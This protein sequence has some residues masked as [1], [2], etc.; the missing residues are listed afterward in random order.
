MGVRVSFSPFSGLLF[1][2]LKLQE[3]KNQ[4]CSKLWGPIFC[5]PGPHPA[6]PLVVKKSV[7]S[8]VVKGGGFGLHIKKKLKKEN[9]TNKV[10][11]PIY[12]DGL[13]FCSCNLN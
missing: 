13:H 10:G 1:L 11:T 8:Q 5:L 4:G 3:K 6:A 7:N 12:F 2:S 9:K